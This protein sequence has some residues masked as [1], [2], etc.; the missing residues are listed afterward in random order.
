[1]NINVFS[2]LSRGALPVMAGL[3]LCSSCV[4]DSFVEDTWDR[5]PMLKYWAD[6]IIIPSWVSY[7]SQTDNMVLAVD[8]FS[9]DPT[10]INYDVFKASVLSAYSGWQWV[11]FLEIGPGE[12]ESAR[13]RTN[14]F[15]AD[16]AKISNAATNY[17]GLNGP[18]FMLP[19]TYSEQGFPAIDFL[20]NSFSSS[21]TAAIYFANNDGPLLY[22]VALVGELNE[23]SKTVLL[24]WNSYRTVFISN[25]GSSASSSLNKIANDYIFHYE[26][27]LRAGKI[28]IPAGVFSSNTYPRKVEAFYSDTWSSILFTEGL[29][30]HSRFFNGV[31]FDSL[32]VG[33]SFAQYLD[34]LNVRR[35]DTTLSF[36][37]SDQFNITRQTSETIT[38]TYSTTIGQNVF[39]MLSLYDDLQVN[40]INMKTDMLQAFN[41]KVDYVDADGD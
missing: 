35:G 27:E 32:L 2:L 38:E 39:K 28:G 13:Y 10:A 17:N 23:I 30:A 1:M 34:H 18:N 33:P 29:R 7:S 14:T 22:L 15:P 21:Q 40:T 37:I 9:D 8:A 12:A 16:T 31:S 36:V 26:K 19:S 25:D 3:L 41:V 5:E 11:S 6:E 20:L 24:E 4:T